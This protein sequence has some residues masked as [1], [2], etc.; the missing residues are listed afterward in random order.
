MASMTATIYIGAFVIGVGTGM[1]DALLTPLVCAIYPETRIKVT[2]QLHMF[3]PMGILIL[4][5]LV[6]FLFKQHWTWREIYSLLAILSLPYGLIFLFLPLPRRLHSGSE[7]IPVR[8]LLREP[9][10]FLLMIAMLLA[11]TT[12][13]GPAQ[14]LPAYVEEG[15]AGTNIGGAIGLL[16]FGITMTTGRVLNSF[17]IQHLNLRWYF[18]GGAIICILSLLLASIPAPMIFTVV[19]LAMVGFGIS[20]FWATLLAT[21]GNRFP[22]AGASM[23]SLM[24]AAGNFGGV[25][26]PVLIGSAA[27]R[28]GLRVGIGLLTIIPIIL[29]FVLLGILRQRD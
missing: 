9:R 16:A 11:G 25:L 3:Y 29:V 5:G 21:A 4:I 6:I 2:N 8:Q 12:E 20:G 22:H 15:L 10:F 26:G 1:V 23:F 19:C 13:L 27:D 17:L 18:L 7:R 14:W 28:W 24:G